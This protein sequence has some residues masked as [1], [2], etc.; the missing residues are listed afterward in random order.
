MTTRPQDQPFRL[1]ALL[2][3][4]LAALS[5][6]RSGWEDLFQLSAFSI[7]VLSR[8]PCPLADRVVNFGGFAESQ[9]QAPRTRPASG[10]TDAPAPN[11][12]FVLPGSGFLASFCA[13]RSP[14]VALYRTW[15]HVMV[16][17]AMNFFSSLLGHPRAA[18]LALVALLIALPT[19]GDERSKEVDDVVWW[20]RSVP[21]NG[22]YNFVRG[23]SNKT[24]TPLFVDWPVASIDKK[25]VPS[26]SNYSESFGPYP[27][28]TVEEGNLEYTIVPK[29]TPT[30]VIKGDGEPKNS[31][32]FAIVGAVLPGGKADR[33]PVALN[34]H[35][36]SEWK[37]A[38]SGYTYSYSLSQQGEPLRVVLSFE[39]PNFFQ[40]QLWSRGSTEA[41]NLSS[42]SGKVV[43]SGTTNGKPRFIQGTMVLQ[44][45]DHEPLVTRTLGLFVPE[46]D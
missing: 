25:W 19:Y 1:D 3:I 12:R 13:G 2:R 9:N 43:L 37:A 24:D 14:K 20:S 8:R 16:S 27:L 41:L 18:V 23:V 11:S 44:T 35:W 34:F 21:A 45:R 31:A 4:G 33:Y 10:Q 7:S 46:G 5:R 36:T 29:R 17:T 32:S 30:T 39:K 26:R 40:K 15:K 22:G 38:G 6:C 28:Q 42:D